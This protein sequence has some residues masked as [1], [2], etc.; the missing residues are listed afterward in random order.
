M[1]SAI[2]NVYTPANRDKTRNVLSEHDLRP[3]EPKPVSM[4]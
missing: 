3:Y 4:A 2:M 1:R